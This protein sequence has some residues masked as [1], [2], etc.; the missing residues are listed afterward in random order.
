MGNIVASGS[1]GGVAGECT[2]I[3]RH[4]GARAVLNRAVQQDGIIVGPLGHRVQSGD[5][6]QIRLLVGI[7]GFLL[8]DSRALHVLAEV[9]KASEELGVV[10]GVPVTSLSN[11][12][13]AP[14]IGLKERNYEQESK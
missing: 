7:R 9:G 12:A 5:F 10:V 2:T 8:V 6:V 14:S 4:T 3:D 13:E 11:A 1:A